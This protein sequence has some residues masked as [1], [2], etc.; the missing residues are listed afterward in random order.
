MRSRLFAMFFMAFSPFS[1]LFSQSEFLDSTFGY[2][3][4][5]F[6]H[7]LP[8][9]D[10]GF[11]VLY[12]PDG[13]ILVAGRSVADSANQ[14]S[15]VQYL[16]DGRLDHDFDIDGKRTVNFGAG[17]EIA[18]AAALLPDGRAVVA[19]FAGDAGFEDFAVTRLTPEGQPDV[20]FAGT[21]KASY[22][23]NFGMDYA[24]A[25]MLQ[26]DGKI[27]LAGYTSPD[28]FESDFA[29]LRLLP[30]GQPDPDFGVDGRVVQ[31][32]SAV[33]DLIFDAKLQADGK[34]V[35]AGQV[36][37][38]DFSSDFIV[39]R[40]RSDGQLDTDFADNGV[41]RLD[42]GND[43]LARGIALQSDG[44]IV[45]AGVTVLDFFP[46][47]GVVRLLSNGLADD[48]FG[49]NG[50]L[51]I[52]PGPAGNFCT[53][54][55]AQPDGGILLSGMLENTDFRDFFL[56]RL[57]P[58]GSPDISFGNA[59]QVISSVSPT[60]D[61]AYRMAVDASG[62][63]LLA[64]TSERT[65]NAD[66]ALLR[67]SADGHPDTDFGQ[68]G[69]VLTDVDASFDLL[70]KMLLL[71]DEK[72]LCAGSAYKAAGSGFE[73]YPGILRLQPNGAPDASF[74]QAE[75]FLNPPAQGT[76]LDI[77][78]ASDGKI[79]GAGMF[80]GVAGLIRLEENGQPDASFGANGI[81]TSSFGEGSSY[82]ALAFTPDGKLLAA[83]ASPLP[84]QEGVM[85]R[86]TSQ[87]AFD[88][89]FGLNGQAQAPA[90]FLV[91]EQ[92]HTLSDGKFLALGT[93]WVSGSSR[94]YLV[95]FLENGSV[96]LNFGSGG[97]VIDAGMPGSQQNA[98]TFLR[99]PSGKL[100]VAGGGGSFAFAQLLPNG[101]IDP[102]FGNNGF[103]AHTFGNDDNA[104]VVDLAVQADGRIVAVGKSGVTNNADPD[105]QIAI[106]RLLPDGNL[107]TDFG[108]NGII[109]LAGK[110]ALQVIPLDNDQL[111]VGG[112]QNNG[113]N[114]DV[115]LVRLVEIPSVGVV[116]ATSANNL[117]V[118]LYP[119]PVSSAI[120][121]NYELLSG[122][123]VR[124]DCYDET[125][126]LM[127]NFLP[128]VARQAGA[129]QET[130][131]LPAHWPAGVYTLVL[132]AG[133]GSQSLKF[134][135]L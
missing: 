6:L 81:A 23:F 35:V 74:G 50:I 115:V 104:I 55:L 105:F 133:A 129:Q 95:Q 37:N 111:L 14:F 80:N 134:V 107:D 131:E 58:D 116:D 9:D 82:H 57:L 75:S 109:R 71:P 114:D 13:R 91:W 66:F 90:G 49:D 33:S 4:R 69:V 2:K 22:D 78:R 30:N 16:P 20:S 128:G 34:I 130:I 28:G 45:V 19:G 132:H 119:N 12:R 85:V 25:V 77:V 127:A 62:D 60:N 53:D 83:G 86:Y 99:L 18:Y 31:S 17:Q 93:R 108:I 102:A 52:E 100:L 97:L 76:L 124:I 11:A 70:Y 125:G 51:T 7:V 135:K 92:L 27:V 64:G 10:Q 88:L 47:V 84:V 98:N 120:Q 89:N 126:R 67:Y 43:D 38:D 21:G 87:G 42:L 40:Y 46:R 29:L 73:F 48:S 121:L 61:N 39:A 72:I 24:Y 54:V 26:P 56:L 3:G 79:A 113:Q 112:Q 65:I 117:A 41:A 123:T 59:G 68:N 63:I 103:I 106:T 5:Q 122:Q 94:D 118:S 110:V 96:D 36:Y 1:L 8:S 15:V 32:F 101:A 44:K